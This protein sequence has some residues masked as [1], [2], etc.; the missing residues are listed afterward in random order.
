MFGWVE[1]TKKTTQLLAL[2][3]VEARQTRWRQ[4]PCA[5]VVQKDREHVALVQP[6]TVVFR[7]ERRCRQSLPC[8]Q[9]GCVV[10]EATELLD[11]VPRQGSG[12]R[13]RVDLC[14]PEYM[15]FFGLVFVHLEVPPGEDRSCRSLDPGHGSSVVADGVRVV[16]VGDR[17]LEKAAFF[18]ERLRE[19]L[20]RGV[21][22]HDEQCQRQRVALW[23]AD[24]GLERAMRL[25]VNAQPERRGRGSMRTRLTSSSSRKPR[26]TVRS[27]ERS[28]MSNTREKSIP[29]I[30]NCSSYWR[31]RATRHL[32]DHTTSAVLRPG[33]KLLW[34]ASICLSS[35]SWIRLSATTETALRIQ[36]NST[37]GRRLEHTHWGLLGLGRQ[38]SVPS[39]SWIGCT[40][41]KLSLSSLASGVATRSAAALRTSAGMLSG[42]QARL[43]RSF[44]IASWSSSGVNGLVERL[45]CR[46]GLHGGAGR[47]GELGQEMSGHVLG[48]LLRVHD[49][50]AVLVLEAKLG[51]GASDRGF[52]G[53]G[54]L[55]GRA[56]GLDLT[57]V[58]IG[59][60]VGKVAATHA[61]PMYD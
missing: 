38:I 10:E 53:C 51:R 20:E 57:D 28:I 25:A 32:C 35:F 15:R 43:L 8:T 36:L 60:G 44:L 16:G 21:E 31:I 1:D 27:F 24:V 47:A 26:S 11:R 3:A 5:T 40:L 9:I 34:Y 6:R 52:D 45:C 17:V 12:V 39:P 4:C 37:I 46:V 59:F 22:V 18:A 49:D 14:R 61:D 23:R 50:V 7:D 33:R 58:G 42:P 55:R 41:A 48:C 30:E 19:V 54:H 2:E 29:R 13:R 56:Q